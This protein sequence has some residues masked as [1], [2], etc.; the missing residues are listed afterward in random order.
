M[1]GSWHAAL[2]YAVSGQEL[3]LGEQTAP[4]VAALAAELTRRGVACDEHRRT[5][6]AHL[7][8]G[9]SYAQLAAAEADLRAR[10]GVSG[11]PKRVAD[12]QARPD[13]RDRRLMADRP[14]HWG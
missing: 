4:D 1:S 10:L 9:L 7:R 8:Q 14:P 11:F 5:I 2:A 3:E 6:P 13:E 12:P